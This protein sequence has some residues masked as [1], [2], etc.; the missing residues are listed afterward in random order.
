MLY[1]ESFE[2]HVSPIAGL[3]TSCANLHSDPMMYAEKNGNIVGCNEQL[4]E[5]FNVTS[6]LEMDP[7]TVWFS[8]QEVELPFLLTHPGTYQGKIRSG[9][10]E[11]DVAVKSELLGWEEQSFIALVFRD[12]SEIER[13]RAAERYFELL[14]KKFL[15]NI[16]HEFRTPM[17]AIIGFS[18][19]LKSTPLNVSQEEYVEMTSRSAVSMMRNIENL[20]EL[21]QVESGSVHTNATLFNPLEIYE[22]MSIQFE[23]FARSKEIG[24]M[25]LIDPHLPKTMMGDQ[26]K[27]IAV[28]RNLIQNGIKFTEEKGRVLVEILIVHEEGNFVEVEYAVSDTG[29]GIESERVKTLLRPFASAW[30]NQRAGK[31]GLGIGLSL[32]HKY[33][34]MMDSHLMLAS[35]YGKG[36][37]FSF[38]IVHQI[39]EGCQFE[40][41]QG[42]RAAIYSEGNLLSSQGALLQKYLEIFQM[43]PF[44]THN[45]TDTALYEC[46]LL[47]LDT[48]HSSDAQIE[49]LHSTYSNLLIVPILEGDE[50]I[51][52]AD[53]TIQLPILPG[54]LYK[55]LSIFRHQT[56]KEGTVASPVVVRFAR[57]ENVKILVAEDNLINLKL[58][59]TILLQQH[60]RVISVENGQQA[61]DAYLKE[62][63]DL[64]LM[65][66]DM[67]VMDGLMANRL[68]KEIDKRADRGYV[69]VIALTAHA[70]I[71]DRERIVAA[72]L[73]GHLAKPI[74]KNFL[75][76]TIDRYLKIAQQKRQQPSI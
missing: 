10:K 3:L 52:A 9:E 30:E 38:R 67:P 55:T 68:I 57:Q 51:S 8:T 65:D 53:A 5:L 20:L 14:K 45:L 4:L 27:I 58:L 33:V 11:Y 26:D 37:R 43:K 34:D 25:F 71:G 74:D 32:S 36:S 63:F 28:L 41:I 46:D 39:N 72:G 60:F 22:D 1:L 69:P 23:D 61:V 44:V 70:L 48:R 29:I 16:S 75:L 49:S 12:N 2:K 66:I 76:Q 62:P 40:F 18:D 56:L 24:L 64:V 19:L 21:M 47:F 31:D 7:L 6:L 17:N 42:K 73:D 35:E 13:A 54:K 15:T 50:D 59:E